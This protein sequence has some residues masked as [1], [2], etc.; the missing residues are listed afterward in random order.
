MPP[1]PCRNDTNRTG[2]QFR[3]TRWV[4]PKV[5]R[6]QRSGVALCGTIVRNWRSAIYRDGIAAARHGAG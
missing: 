4:A 2:T 3:A 5:R 6:T 1:A